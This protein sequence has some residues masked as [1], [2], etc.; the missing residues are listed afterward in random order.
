MSEGRVILGMDIGGTNVRSGFVDEQCG[1]ADFRVKKNTEIFTG[2]DCD[3][4]AILL[5]YIGVLLEKYGKRPGLVSL[6]LPSTVHKNN[7]VVYSTPNIPGLDNIDFASLLE[8]RYQIPALISRDVCLLLLYD[9][10]I[11]NLKKEGFIVGFYVGTGTGNAISMNGEI[12]VG[13]NGAAAELGHIPVLGRDDLCVCGNRGCIEIYT[14]GKYLS[15][16]RDEYF[17]EE[18]FSN[19]FIKH[20]TSP[21]IETFVDNMAAAIAT[22][23]NILDP[24][25]IVLGGGVIMQNGFPRAKLEN[26]VKKYTRKPYPAENLNFVYTREGAENGVIGAGIFGFQK[27]GT[28][29]P[30]DTA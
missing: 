2:P 23:I 25:V 8:E 18:K 20:E 19:L 30:L 15:W 14:S 6:G 7:R 24:E 21:V 22:E 13:K 3:G 29:V 11:H 27:M 12:V 4:A 26:A 10:Y 17:P 9:I 5:D 28:L 16:V 1:L